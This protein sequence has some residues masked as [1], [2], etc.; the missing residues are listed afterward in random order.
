MNTHNSN[1]TWEDDSFE[2]T[3]FIKVHKGSAGT[4]TLTYDLVDG[5]SDMSG[6]ST[7][8]LVTSSET[9]AFVPSVRNKK[10]LYVQ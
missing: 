7:L 8:Q 6:T 5:N 4:S 10:I 3:A 1:L 2:L 9:I